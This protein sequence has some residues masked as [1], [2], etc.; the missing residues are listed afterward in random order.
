MAEKINNLHFGGT[1]VS[2]Q[3]KR[4][5]DKIEINLNNGGQVTVQFMDPEMIKYDITDVFPM[6][7]PVC[8]SKGNVVDLNEKYLELIKEKIISNGIIPFYI[9]MVIRLP[10][11]T[12][13]SEPIITTTD[14]YI[15]IY[16]CKDNGEVKLACVSKKMEEK[17]DQ[18]TNIG[19]ITSIKY[20]RMDWKDVV[21]IL[22]KSG[23]D[24]EASKDASENKSIEIANKSKYSHIITICENLA[25]HFN[26][27]I[28]GVGANKKDNNGN[29]VTK[30]GGDIIEI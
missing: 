18:S 10:I 17:F 6:H 19:K 4:R 25:F 16:E 29:K 3:E 1:I 8:V 28:L 9:P 11:Q 7:V 26:H 22:R 14:S 2:G 23:I 12:F 20:S 13:T 30:D 15:Y 21:S 27:F 5:N 24:L